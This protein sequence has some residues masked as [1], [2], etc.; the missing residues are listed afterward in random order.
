M[1]LLLQLEE[2]PSTTQ[3]QSPCCGFLGMSL[4]TTAQLGQQQAVLQAWPM[5]LTS[6]WGQSF[7]LSPCVLCHCLLGGRE[8]NPSLTTFSLA[9]LTLVH[10]ESN[11]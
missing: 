3:E 4:Q 6:Q 7:I 5:L 9:V 1:L 8:G 2:A 10:Q 11:S